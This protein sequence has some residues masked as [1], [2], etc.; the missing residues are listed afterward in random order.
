MKHV[1]KGVLYLSLIFLFSIGCG[2]T[3]QQNYK[4]HK[5]QKGETVSSVS[6]EYSISKEEIYRLNPDARNGISE[7]SV[8]IL[9]SSAM[10]M[11]EGPIK[12]KM[13]RV[14]RKETL[15]GVAQ[16]Y[17]V[18]M[19][20]IK[21]YN[22]ELYS[23]SLKKGEKI[24]IPIKSKSNSTEVAIN[25]NTS[26]SSNTGIHTI[27]P[28]ET[29]FG[30]A[31]KYGI[32]MAELEAMNPSV[33]DN[34]P[35]GTKLVVPSTSVTNSA[36]IEEDRYDFYEVQPK[37]GFFRLKV[38]L[39]LDQEDI[40][41]LNPYAKDGL[42]EGMIL[43]IP[44]DNELIVLDGAATIVDLE[45]RIRNRSTKRLA[46]MLPFQLQRTNSDSISA[47]EQLIKDNGAL[48]VALDFYSGVLM[49]TEF[50]KDKGISIHLDVYDT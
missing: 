9:P 20:D 47:N 23:R 15:F 14:K 37:E 26:N 29:K 27:K 33:P 34:F 22:K 13:H 39:G 6:R 16:L 7:N 48:R 5:V 38:K 46:V 25:T 40:I 21:K 4:S 44:K 49:A 43:K 30:I 1:L 8:L 41:S 36:T 42:K 12:F 10:T 11:V 31:R 24:R 50:A 17:N 45:S 2:A 3:V 35:I 32:S 28:K 19:D 18:E